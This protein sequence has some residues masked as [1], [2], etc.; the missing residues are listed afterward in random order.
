MGDPEES[1]HS[2]RVGASVTAAETMQRG[3]ARGSRLGLPREVDCTCG[4]SLGSFLTLV[5]PKSVWP[6]RPLAA[7]PS[8]VQTVAPFW[9][10]TV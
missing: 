6:P 9:G 3:S 5:P 4:Y 2:L 8:C 10:L 7:E 1:S